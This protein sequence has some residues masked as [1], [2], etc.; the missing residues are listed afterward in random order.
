M[1]SHTRTRRKTQMHGAKFT[2]STTVRPVVCTPTVTFHQCPELSESFM[3]ATLTITNLDEIQS[4][5]VAHRSE[6]VRIACAEMLLKQSSR[7]RENIDLALM[8]LCNLSILSNDR[9]HRL[10]A[11]Q[12]LQWYQSSL[13][14]ASASAAPNSHLQRRARCATERIEFLLSA[15]ADKK[16]RNS[17]SARGN[18]P[19]PQSH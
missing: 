10:A 9:H 13:K 7:S 8:V 17:E 11:Y 12:I 18:M 1:L 14:S 3:T 15:A 19:P 4:A 6:C 2:R 16:V 5:A